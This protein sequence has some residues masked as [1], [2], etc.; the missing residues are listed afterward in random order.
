MKMRRI[1]SFAAAAVAAL[2]AVSCAHEE[3]DDYK[4]EGETV[5]LTASIG[6]EETKAELGTSANGKP[7]TMWTDGDR[8]TIHNGAKGFEFVT[9]LEEAAPRADFTY[10]G[11][12]FSA[13][14]GVIAV[15]PS[16]EY[17][18]D[19][20]ERTVTLNIPAVQ[21]AA[22]GT[23]DPAAGVL[24]AYTESGS[25][26]MTFRNAA[27]LIKFSMKTEGVKSVVLS[28][29]GEE[30]VC[31][32]TVVTFDADGAIVSVAPKSAGAAGT[33]V[34]LTAAGSGKLAAGKTYYMAVA[35]GS[36]PEGFTVHVKY[37]ADGEMHM[38]KGYTKSYDLERNFILN[39]G[40]FTV[41]ELPVITSLSFDPAKNEGKILSKELYYDESGANGLYTKTR[42]AEAP[43]FTP[44]DGK[45]TGRILYL[46]NRNLVPTLE[47]TEG[48]TVSY[49]VG[50]GDFVN[51]DG[52]S[53]IDFSK[54]TVLR[55]AKDGIFNEY[56]CE[57]TNSGLPV[58]VIN[59]S[60]GDT[61]WSQVG[62]KVWAKETEFDNIITENGFAVYNADGTSG[63]K[64]K[65]GAVVEGA[66]ASA[67][68]LRGNTSQAYPKKPFAVKLDSK[69]EVLGMPA[70]KRWVLLANWKDKSLMCNHVAFGIAQKFVDTFAGNANPGLAWQPHGQ[71]VEVVYNGI[72]IGNYYLCEQIKI[73]GGRLDISDPYDDKD[74]PSITDADLD[75]FG[76]LIECD[77]NYD[78]SENGQF[79][80]K[81]FIPVMLKDAGD[82]DGVILNYIKNKVVTIEDNL[83]NGKYSTAYNDLDKYSFADML[84]VYEMAMNSEMGHPKSAY[85]YV[86]GKGKL[87]GG[88][89][90]D[91]DWTSFPNN[92]LIKSEGFDSSWDRSYTQ[93]L[94]ATSNH[95][96]K[97]YRFKAGWFSSAEY[98]SSVKKD[99]V[100]YL[101]YPMLVKDSDFK[102]VLAERWSVMSPILS[103]Y[104]QEL[105]IGT[106]EEIAVSWEYNNSIWPTYHSK[107]GRSEATGT[108][109]ARGDEKMTSWKEVYTNLYNVYMERLQGMDSFVGAQ[110]WP[111][112][113]INTASK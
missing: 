45:I 18:A 81:H 107:N 41:R 64:D 24:A 54:G 103:A 106:A 72:H 40:E 26:S 34:E 14:N 66:V 102:S 52:T 56:V 49:S 15:Y 19:L 2:A 9:E 6:E 80:S 16:G 33:V 13:D 87:R 69:S 20:A 47:Y 25:A 32:E 17:E 59:Q 100:P 101:W 38:V 97:H 28:G 50:G 85:M 89:V 27:A 94:M 73:D 111:S 29:L 46:N 37:T 3:F 11:N 88:P 84:L 21:T 53:T 48:A 5:V 60:E 61:Q 62:F 12:D 91:F 104:A 82:K 10:V 43:S 93:S 86:D 51:W 7:Q 36:F 55:V 1:C 105:I 42:T 109:A 83:Y 44:A 112:W 113:S 65:N 90:W 77:D 31:G 74:Y 8:I 22:E 67:V 79:L 39:L 108:I 57:I 30:A 23:F 58:V 76:Y 78:E 96:N 110:N 35:P 4:N 99:D 63:L 70:H 71:F 95:K 92:S 68:R 75:K 98:P